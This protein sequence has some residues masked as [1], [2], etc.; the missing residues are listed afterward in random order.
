MAEKRKTPCGA[1]EGHGA[2]RRPLERDYFGDYTV[3][4]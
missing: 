4:R 3:R 1:L 2:E